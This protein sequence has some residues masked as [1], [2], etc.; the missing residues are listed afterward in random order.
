[1]KADR[2][3]DMGFVQD[4]RRVIQKLPQKRQ[5]LFFSATMPPEIEALANNILYEPVRVE[6]T[7]VSSTSEKIEQAV[8]HVGK[9]N[10]RAL[11]V[12]LLN[13]KSIKKRACV[14]PHK[15]WRR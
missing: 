12:H 8:Y 4:V 13:D 3:L 5:T 15:T 9:E 14:Y 6:V 10:K 11:L 1:M 2:M 7:P